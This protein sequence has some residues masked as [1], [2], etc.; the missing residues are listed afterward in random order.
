MAGA[1]ASTTG[2]RSTVHAIQG[3]PA[4]AVTPQQPLHL[5][6][7]LHLVEQI[8]AATR[9]TT[10]V[11]TARKGERN[12]APSVR[13]QPKYCKTDLLV[14]DRLTLRGLV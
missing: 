10:S 3:G 2:T 6:H 9:T 8:R 7:H 5:R 13:G 12:T 4:P 14:G 11:M 1:Q